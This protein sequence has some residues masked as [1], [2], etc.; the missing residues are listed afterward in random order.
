MT[1]F[2]SLP[3][4]LQQF[5]NPAGRTEGIVPVE[6]NHIAA[7]RERHWPRPRDKAGPQESETTTNMEM[8]N[9]ID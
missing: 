2:A 3:L 5:S 8:C 9:I 7:M 1:F 4:V 6:E